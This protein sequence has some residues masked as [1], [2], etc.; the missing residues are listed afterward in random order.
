MSTKSLYVLVD[1][2]SEP[3]TLLGF[4]PII[5]GDDHVQEEFRD[6]LVREGNMHF[7]H[8]G[9]PLEPSSAKTF[10][11]VINQGTEAGHSEK[12]RKLTGFT[13]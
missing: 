10:R 7:L 11:I 12:R 2:L 4:D 6:W 3:N 5:H 9:L 13:G 8:I 1:T